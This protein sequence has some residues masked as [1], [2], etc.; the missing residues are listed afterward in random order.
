LA[1]RAKRSIV[2]PTKNWSYALAVSALGLLAAGAQASP[3]T[4]RATVSC[5]QTLTRSTTLANDLRNCPGNGLVVGARNITVDLAGHTVDGTGARRSVGI[6]NKRYANVTVENGTITDFYF[7]AVGGAGSGEDRPSGNVFRKLTIRRIG[8]GCRQG[9]ICAGIFLLNAPGAT[10]VDNVISNQVRAFQVNGVDVYASPGARVERNRIGPNAGEGLAIFQSPKAR[11]IRNELVAN[12]DGMD[13]NSSSDAVQVVGNRAIGN[14]NAGIAV[15]ALRRARVLGNTATRNGD[16]GLFLF[17]LRDSLARGNRA[18][19]NY[20]G[21]HLYG[22]Q[23]GVA[24]FG[25]KRGAA[26]N[27]LVRNTATKN[28]YAGIWV[29]GDDRRDEVRANLLSGN[30]A[31]GNGRAGGVVVQGS[32]AANT[33]RG[34]T[35][36]ANAGHGIAAAHGA[37]DGGGNRARRNH[38]RP[39]CV[40][41]KC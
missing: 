26:H 29:K 27:R 15:G 8:V 34:N 4:T 21:V 31:N 32:V 38:R 16:D 5:G 12:R 20:T 25:G 24:Q 40:G 2:T 11:I 19:G 30:A 36:N 1:R 13:A 35:A 37:V 10:V 28:R 41:V 33:L 39:Q 23:G 17:D 3:S 6:E 9:D 7:S 18:N 14:R 22:G